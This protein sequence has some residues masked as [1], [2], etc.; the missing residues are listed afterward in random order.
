MTSAPDRELQQ[1]LDVWQTASEPQTG[2]EAIRDYVARRS[3]MLALWFYTEIVIGAVG[4]VLLLHRALTGTDPVEMLA[5]GALAAIAGGSLLFSLWNWRKGLRASSGTTADFVALSIDRVRRMRRAIRF[6]WGILVCEVV[7]FVPWI[8]R[9]L[10]AG[11]QPPS[12]GAERFAWG[13]LLGLTTFALLL[14]VG[15]QRWISRESRIL[16][17]LRHELGPDTDF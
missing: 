15:L 9:Q 4:L 5:M 2:P 12:A 3:L 14:L 16:D 1:W 17:G 10:Y 7:V 11:P 6:G 8:W 13:L